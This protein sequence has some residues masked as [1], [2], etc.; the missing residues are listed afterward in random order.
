MTHACFV[1]GLGLQVNVPIAGLRGLAAPERIDVVM[2]V[3]SMPPHLD[4]A[5]RGSLRDVY[6]SEGWTGEGAPPVRVG[7]LAGGSHYLFSYSDGTRIVVDAAGTSVWATAPEVATLEDTATYL[8]GPILGFVL[9]LRGVTCLHASAV[10]LCDRA[11][12]FV[13]AAGAGKSST[14]AAFAQLGFPVLTDDVA[15]LKDLGE[16]FEIEPAYPRLRLWP[17]SA[18][19][20]F[21]APDALPHITPGWDKRYLDLNAPQYRFM[22]KSLELGAVYVLGDRI[23]GD[24]PCVEPLDARAALMALV[25]ET[26]SNRLIEPRR[27]AAEFDLLARLVE[28]V[29]VRRV[30]ACADF[31][32]MPQL[33]A[34]ILADLRELGCLAQA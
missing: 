14:A 32:R 5:C 13:G 4:D 9:R 6:V 24:L 8:L 10:A 12:A 30:Q 23:E 7:T 28:S 3:G 20:L 26:Y 2:R 34:A 11:I 1:Y 25:A 31:R 21:G 27:R 19:A 17:D 18:A 22:A 29:P 16:R 15:P 33:C